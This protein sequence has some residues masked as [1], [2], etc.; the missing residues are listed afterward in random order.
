MINDA[1]G[2]T[3]PRTIRAGVNGINETVGALTLSNSSVID[4]GTLTGTNN[5]R[6]AASTGLWTAG[7]TLSILNYTGN[8]DHL[9]FGTVTGAG[10]D[11]GQLG[12]INFYS[13]SDA[14]SFLGTAAYLLD[15]EVALGIKLSMDRGAGGLLRLSRSGAD[16]GT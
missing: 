11:T 15:G 7:T 4:F 2:V 9:F 5:L 12:Q 10:V 16:C 8:T 6:F 13:D 14:G 3:S 1:A